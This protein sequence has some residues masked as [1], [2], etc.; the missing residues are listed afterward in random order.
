MLTSS[1]SSDQTAFA[2]THV[3]DCPEGQLAAGMA[4]EVV[5]RE[6]APELTLPLFRPAG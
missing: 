2:V 4:L 5:F 6:L 1:S 3:V